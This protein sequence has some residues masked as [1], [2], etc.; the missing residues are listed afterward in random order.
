[1]ADRY[2]LRPRPLAGAKAGAAVMGFLLI[3]RSVSVGFTW[4][5]VVSYLACGAAAGLLV[6]LCIPFTRTR[7]GSA[8]VGMVAL[9]PVLAAQATFERL[10][11]WTYVISAICVG[12][13]AGYLIRDQVYPELDN[14]TSRPRQLPQDRR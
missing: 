13:L 9:A 5:A 8:L 12:G 2:P 4:T 14:L 1:M 6:G 3:V 7:L 11:W 10:E